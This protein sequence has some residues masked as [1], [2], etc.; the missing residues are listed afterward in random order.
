MPSHEVTYSLSGALRL[1]TPSRSRKTKLILGKL[2]A[3]PR[4][5]AHFPLLGFPAILIASVPHGHTVVREVNRALAIKLLRPTLACH[6]QLN[7]PLNSAVMNLTLSLP[8][9]RNGQAEGKHFDFNMHSCRTCP[10][11]QLT[12]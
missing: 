8:Y 1:M 9:R 2:I 6:E 12:R 3:P 7:I 4:L 11:A 10:K 5:A